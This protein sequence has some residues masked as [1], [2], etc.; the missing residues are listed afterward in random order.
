M[1]KE[2]PMREVRLEKVTLNIGCGKSAEKLEKGAK[3]LAELTGRQ[4]VKTITK[5]RI[6]SWGIRPGLPIGLK[7]TVRGRAAAELLNRC[8]EAVDHELPPSAFDE[9]GNVA[10]GIPEQIDIPGMSYSPEIG[11]LGLQLCVTLCRPGF[12]VL[13]RRAAAAIPARHRIGREEA[14]AFMAKTFGLRLKE[15]A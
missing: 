3:V 2:N 13:R 8:L 11:I 1:K 12:R 15:S 10:F 7:L 4:P 6:P 9:R 5:K 14:I